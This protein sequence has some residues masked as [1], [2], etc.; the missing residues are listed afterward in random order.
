VHSLNGRPHAADIRNP[1]LMAAIEL[2]PR[3]DGPGRRGHD[4]FL[5]CYNAG[6]YVRVTGDTV[7]MS[8]PFI[9]AKDDIARAI[10]ALSTALGR[11]A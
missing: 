6:V 11:V 5:D 4:V 10:D 9:I 7:A 8:P 2:S 1:G 3:E